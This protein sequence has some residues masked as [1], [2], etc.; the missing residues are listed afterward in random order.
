MSLKASHIPGVALK[1]GALLVLSC[2]LPASYDD[3]QLSRRMRRKL[4]HFQQKVR[5]HKRK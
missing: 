5:S 2:P 1:C 3:A 4:P